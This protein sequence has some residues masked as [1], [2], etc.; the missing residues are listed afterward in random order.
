MPPTFISDQDQLEAFRAGV[1]ELGGMRETA[2]LFGVN[3]RTLRDIVQ[4]PPRRKLHTGFMRDL[5]AQLIAKADRCR[6]LERRI[7]PAFEANLTAEQA[8]GEDGRKLR[9]DRERREPRPQVAQ[10]DRAEK[11]HG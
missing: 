11:A 4:D 6:A 5:A 9:Y 10:G 1:E 8:A 3:E 2:R 7:S